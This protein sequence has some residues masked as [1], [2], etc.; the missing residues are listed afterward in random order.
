MP[1]QAQSPFGIGLILN[2]GVA[3][4]LTWTIY[5]DVYDIPE[6]LG[7]LVRIYFTQTSYVT[8]K[9]LLETWVGALAIKV[10]KWC[11]SAALIIVVLPFALVWQL[12][13]ASFIAVERA[14]NQRKHMAALDSSIGQ[15]S[16]NPSS[17]ALSVQAGHANA[18]PVT[19]KSTYQY[20]RL[21]G[22]DEIRL[23]ELF[24][25]DDT[26]GHGHQKQLRGRI[27]HARLG[28]SPRFSALSYCWNDMA[29]AGPAKDSI[30]PVLDLDL[31]GCLVLT[32]NLFTG[33]QSAL[34][35]GHFESNLF[36]VDQI[37]INQQDLNEKSTQVF[38][39][40]D[41]Y[42]QAALVL[43]WLGDDSPTGDAGRA[44]R[45]AE[46]IAKCIDDKGLLSP[47]FDFFPI[48]FTSNNL[49]LPPIHDAIIDYVA[50]FKL[51]TR[52]WFERSWIVQEVSLNANKRVL[53]G[54]T[55]TSFDTLA[56]ALLFCTR[57]MDFLAAWVP[58]EARAAFRAMIQS[59][60]LTRRD[61]APPSSG[62]LDV[63]VRHR[64]CKAT[65]PSDKVFAFLNISEDGESLDIKPDYTVC[66][67]TVFIKTAVAMIKCYENLDILSSANAWPYGHTHGLAT[68]SGPSASTASH[69]CLDATAACQ[70]QNH[71]DR[72]PS[73][74]PDW[75]V[76][77]FAPSLQ[78]KGE[79]GEYFS[80]YR[81]TGSSVKT[82]QFRQNNTQLG[83]EGHVLDRIIS[84]G[85]GFVDDS[86]I[87]IGYAYRT[88]KSWGDMCGAWSRKDKY[89]FTEEDM[90]AAFANTLTCGGKDVTKNSPKPTPPIS[91]NPPKG[92]SKSADK[93]DWL[94]GDSS[95][96][97]QF[98][99][100]LVVL[101]TNW[102]INGIWPSVAGRPFIYGALN[103][104]FSLVVYLWEAARKLLGLGV[105]LASV[106]PGFRQRLFASITH[107]RFIY[108]KAGLIGLVSPQAE[109][110]DCIAL[111][112]GANVP[113][114]VRYASGT[115]D[116][117]ETAWEIVGDAYV[118]GIMF[119]E[120]FLPEEERY[121]V[122]IS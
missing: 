105:P 65:L 95:F 112:A 8:M 24:P 23:L 118:H 26:D 31:E 22:D 25:A 41:I 39:M 78:S 51:L 71:P 120:A 42:K 113:V 2:L 60:V 114:V 80:N 7:W 63:L 84:V 44:L 1:P 75:S 97:A 20:Q 28:D 107:R 47:E 10:V 101:R 58:L 110:G 55:E 49:G 85:P 14:V 9:A 93:E 100:L 74:V 40:K 3:V 12:G 76:P 67:R 57:S 32:G 33:L 73:W 66:S 43:V 18:A 5:S 17:E 4:S 88:I 83:V 92:Q 46:H 29:Y 59:S 98:N 117:S 77:T 111:F 56:T 50:L 82:V 45:F 96:P 13:K 90:L 122:W 15:I 16:P 108:T 37:C 102:I 121:T 64:G 70:D 72:L 79:F 91:T 27:I 116:G 48:T 86:G 62:L 69:V 115:P 94:G 36:W 104:L 106:S 89:I 87:D 103:T 6:S 11:L 119:G 99:Q 30:N 53:C 52:P 81:A 38:L 109:P 19:V 54:S 21:W 34:E 61:Y 68:C 35:R